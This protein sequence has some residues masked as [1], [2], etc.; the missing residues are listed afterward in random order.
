MGT[1]AAVRTVG[2]VGGFVGGFGPA[3]G[4]F[5]R[6]SRFFNFEFGFCP[7]FFLQFLSFF[8]GEFLFDFFEW[9]WP[10]MLLVVRLYR[11]VNRSDLSWF[12]HR[13]GRRSTATGANRCR[14]RD[15]QRDQED[16][17]R[18]DLLELR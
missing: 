1:V 4:G 12:V 7:R 2:V 9:R 6:S 18:A 13:F 5:E 14:H 11:F 8:F 16:T 10:G 3:G 15:A 17:L